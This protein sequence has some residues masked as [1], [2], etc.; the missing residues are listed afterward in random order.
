[1]LRITVERYQRIGLW[2][3]RHNATLGQIRFDQSEAINFPLLAMMVAGYIH[4][5][6]SD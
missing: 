3:I 1:M 4:Q 5:L 6:V 2:K